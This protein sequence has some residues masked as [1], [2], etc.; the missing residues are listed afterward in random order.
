MA[1]T[2]SRNG[3]VALD[4]AERAILLE[5]ARA[6]IGDGLHGAEPRVADLDAR[7]PALRAPAATFVTLQLHGA[8]RGCIGTLDA[9]QPM[10][11]D[12][13][14]NAYAAAYRDPRFAPLTA[15]EF[16]RVEIHISILNPPEPLSFTD[17]DDLIALLRPGIDGLI[18][19]ERGRRGTFLPAVW[20]SVPDAREF[21]SQL[22]VKAGLPATYWSDAIK[23]S[24][25]TTI[26]IP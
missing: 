19:S 3:D 7:T 22:K 6:A 26:N 11:I 13:A 17:E 16:E 5:V 10:V 25:Y 9:V 18:L 1:L 24:R 21:L 12:A 20:E 23:V 14:A 15:P 8:L 2:F 4:A